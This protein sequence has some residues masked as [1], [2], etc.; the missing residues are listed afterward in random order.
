MLLKNYK[1]NLTNKIKYDISEYKNKKLNEHLKSLDIRDNSLWKGI[2]IRKNRNNSTPPFSY[3]N[4]VLLDD[5][6]KA[7]ALSDVFERVQYLTKSNTDRKTEYDVA[8]SHTGITKTALDK[9]EIPLITPREVADAI[10]QTK[11]KKTPGFDGLQN[12]VLKNLSK[13]SIVQLLYILN[14]CINL[15]YFPDKWKK[16]KMLAFHKSDKPKYSPNSYRPI[17]LLPT[18]AEIVEIIVNKRL[19]KYLLDSSVLL[20][21]Q[22]GFRKSRS[23]CQQL[24][25]LTNHISLNFNRSRSTGLLLLDIKKAFDT[26]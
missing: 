25:R 21:E 11:P 7:N 9:A 8:Q 15:S 10:K 26:V 23:T 2:K 22:F 3:N 19:A 17:R 16:A 12:I 14:S 18:L 4:Q 6:S 13:K 20:D 1:N 5:R 24:A